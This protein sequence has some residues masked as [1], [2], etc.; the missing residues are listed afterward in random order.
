EV[1]YIISKLEAIGFKCTLH[2]GS[3]Y[4]QPAIVAQR[5]ATFEG[6]NKI[7]I[8]NHY[9]VEPIHRKDWNYPPFELSEDQERLF[10]RGIADNKGVL[11]ARILTLEYLWEQQLASPSILWLIQGEE[12]AGAEVAYK[13][14][15]NAINAFQSQLYLEETGYH[16]ENQQLLLVKP[17]SSKSKEIIPQIIHALDIKRPL[18][19]ERHLNKSYANKPCPFLS[20]IPKEGIYLAIGPNDQQCRIH[21]NNESLSISKLKESILQF[22]Q[23]LSFLAKKETQ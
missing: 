5:N 2:E 22:K 23:L 12:E 8:Y 10:G 6:K 1:K 20:A 11:W 21:K 4:H 19:E 3:P 9:D 14:F 7:C 17:Y 16:K 13:P 15:Q 18:I